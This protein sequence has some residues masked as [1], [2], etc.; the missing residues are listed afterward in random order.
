MAAYRVLLYYHFAP[1][2]EPETFAQ[3][4]LEQCH[5]LGL[6][7]R[8]IVAEEGING[9]VSGTADVCEAYMAGLRAVPGFESIQFK[10]DET[11]AHAFKRLSV[12]CRAEIVTLGEPLEQP[13]HQR[14]GGYLSPSEWREAMHRP[15]VV[16]LDGRNDYE[17]ELGR[18]SGAICPPL[19]NF[20]EFPEWLREHRAELEGK[21]ILTYCTGGIRCE[22]LTA[23]MLQEGFRDVFQLHGGIVN[24]GKDP[25]TQGEGFEGV[26]VVFDDRVVVPAGERATPI[27]ACARCGESTTNYVNCANVDCNKRMLMCEACENETERTCSVAC[28]QS[29]RKRPKGGRL[30]PVGP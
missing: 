11:D 23:W 20:R 9:T 8:I 26:N 19:G 7:G 28:L 30:Q 16:I 22:K 24:Y 15:D 21:T 25:A 4:H 5:E 10:I 3:R 29:E 1:L 17:S 12:K 27:N 13:V 2:A 6:R 14:T 18:F